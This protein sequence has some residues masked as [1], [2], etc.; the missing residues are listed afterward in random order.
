ML[1]AMVAM[2]TNNMGIMAKFVSIKSGSIWAY[3]YDMHLVLHGGHIIAMTDYLACVLS[4]RIQRHY[5][6]TTRAIHVFYM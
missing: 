5:I 2:T 3:E 6:L 4:T 1:V